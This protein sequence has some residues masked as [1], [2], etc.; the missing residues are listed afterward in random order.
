MIEEPGELAGTN[1]GGLINHHD[2]PRSELG[3]AEVAE[4]P[5]DGAGRDAGVVLEMLGR[6]GGER[7]A[8][9][10]IP[11]GL[12]RLPCR[13]ERERLPRPSDTLDDLDPVTRRADRVHHV[14]LLRRQG[15]PSRHGGLDRGGT[16]D[17]AAGGLPEEPGV[18][19]G[20]FDLEHLG[21]G[22]PPLRGS[23]GDDPAVVAA[24]GG[25]V[26]VTPDGQDVLG[27]HEPVDQVQDV[28]DPAPVG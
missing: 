12:P 9:H 18:D 21:G 8:D 19:H 4:E 28:L 2:R 24:D 22:P 25:G 23:G 7:A 15:A 27:A 11:G 5:V 6:P 14:V 26:T 1:H 17:P 13:R 10:P 20:Q 16:R 3:A